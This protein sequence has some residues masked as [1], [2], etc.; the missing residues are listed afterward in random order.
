MADDS[1]KG[2]DVGI[3]EV[4]RMVEDFDDLESDLFGG[5]TRNKNSAEAKSRGRETQKKVAFQDFEDESL[6]D[7]LLSEGMDS[8]KNSKPLLRDSKSTKVADL[9]KIESAESRG[10]STNAPAFSESSVSA[11]PPQKDIFL[12]KHSEK[13]STNDPPRSL[14][15]FE[16]PKAEIP[17]VKM[18]D[19]TKKSSLMEDLFGSR[20]RASSLKDI[21]KNSTKKTNETAEKFSESMPNLLERDQLGKS[22][23][24]GFTLTSS[25]SREPRRGRGKST[26]VDDPLGLLASSNTPQE[27]QIPEKK[28][29]PVERKTQPPDPQDDLPEWL[30][31]S[32][33]SDKSEIKPQGAETPQ[34]SLVLQSDKR[35]FPHTEI[36]QLTAVQFEQQAAL[37]TLQQQEHELRAAAVLSQQSE[38][39]QTIINRQKGQFNEQE[40]MFNMLVRKQMDRQA[41]LDMEIKMQQAKID[42]YIQALAKEPVDSLPN[43]HS[44]NEEFGMTKE[45]KLRESIPIESEGLIN[46]LELEKQNLE[47]I[48]DILKEKHE[49]EIKIL[50][51]SHETQMHFM[52]SSMERLETKLREDTETLEKDYEKKIEKLGDEKNQMEALFR[53]Q[54]RNLKEEYKEIINEM[55]ARHKDQLTLLQNEHSETIENISRAKQLERKAVDFM[56]SNKTSLELILNN[57]KEIFDNFQNISDQLKSKETDLITKKERDLMKLEEQLQ[58]LREQLNSQQELLETE[59][60]GLAIA[61]HNLKSEKSELS[62]QFQRNTEL[63]NETE[64]RLRIREQALIK[65]RELFQE[66]N[67]WERDHLQYLKEAWM[68]EQKR[69]MQQLA[70]D[71]EAAAAEKAKL[72]VLNY[73]KTNSDDV[74]KGELE[75]AIKA[76]HDAAHSANLERKKWQERIKAYETDRE[77]ILVK[78]RH[79]TE[80]AKE[81]EDLTQSAILKREEGMRALKEAQR[82]EK[83]H[84][85]RMSQLE[86]QMELLAQRENKIATEKLSLA[87]DRLAVKIHQE[88]PEKDVTNNSFHSQVHQPYYLSQMQTH[89]RDVVDPQLLLLKL[90]LDNKLDTSNQL[91]SDM[92]TVG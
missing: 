52:R 73:L 46:K 56:E 91:I 41:A 71:R 28:L 87:R 11:K 76:A 35:T 67:K 86:M 31:G 84:K 23:S 20:S 19:R 39:L 69:Q 89:F 42:H 24:G 12:E 9:F 50:E 68:T 25:S 30:G 32:K 36:S 4:A 75:A 7:D 17:E 85:E 51:E 90:N 82:I 3:D 78:E 83:Q 72:E 66:Q 43:F 2:S 21:S 45:D 65:E 64:T 37:I 59:R 49:R 61:A 55:H 58:G 44:E 38:H 80:R 13:L 8:A 6:L 40:R 77:R 47:N 74:T 18:P 92:Q 57:S 48:V 79:L 54:I 15:P 62:L 34:Q 5:S 29:E 16:P 70:A 63:Y 88:K 60:K 53:E 26:P 81:L 1:D 14:E 33:R 22:S 10:L 27:P